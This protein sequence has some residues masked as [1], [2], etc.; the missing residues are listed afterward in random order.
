M[1]RDMCT[2]LLFILLLLQGWLMGYIVL[3]FIIVWCTNGGIVY[4]M[5]VTF[6]EKY[7]ATSRCVFGP[8][9]GI[10]RNV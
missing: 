4:I 7:S 10:V 6:K 3:H 9:S 2:V 1:Y 8:N 5:D